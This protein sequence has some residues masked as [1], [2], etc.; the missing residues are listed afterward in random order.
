MG[1]STQNTQTAQSGTSTTTPVQQQ[2]ILAGF[3]AL[4]GVT[5]SATAGTAPITSLAESTTPALVNALSAQGGALSDLGTGALASGVSGLANFNPNTYVGTSPVLSGANA[6]MQG[7]NPTAQTNAAEAGALQQ[8]QQGALPAIASNAASTGN[9]N[10]SGTANSSEALQQAFQNNYNNLYGSISSQDYS[11]ALGTSA[12]LGLGALS[13]ALGANTALT[14]AGTAAAG[15]GQAAE[16]AIPGVESAGLSNVLG[17]SFGPLATELGLLSTNAGGTS[18]GTQT[19]TTNQQTTPSALS[20]I[21]SLLGGAGSVIGGTGANGV[22]TGLG[23]IS[24]I[25]SLLKMLSPG[26]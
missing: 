14:G 23:G 18:T 9:I 20:L 6:F 15:L 22:T 12:G 17:G 13:G 16:T 24:G 5:S 3:G 26:S 19:G 8:L 10:S 2:Q 4:P 7:F 21:G 11:N 1:T 25:T